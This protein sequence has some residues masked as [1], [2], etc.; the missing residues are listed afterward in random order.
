MSERS[1]IPRAEIV[2]ARSQLALLFPACI[3]PK[4]GAKRPLIKRID[5]ELWHAMPKP[6][7]MTRRLFRRALGWYVRS[8]R[9]HLAVAAGGAR[10]GPDGAAAAFI[11]ASEQ[12][13]AIE[14]L[15]ALHE[16]RV[17]KKLAA[18]YETPAEIETWLAA[19]HKLLGDARAQD[20]IRAGRG[21]EVLACIAQLEDGAYV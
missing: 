8:E 17:R 12:R 4:G 7:P 14:Q 19:P 2:A 5:R 10:I 9:Y 6:Q 16:R 20:L 11:T 18:L 1:W 15:A 21:T 3:A 13:H